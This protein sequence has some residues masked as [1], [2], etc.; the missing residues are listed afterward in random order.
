ML[1][2][3]NP[4]RPCTTAMIALGTL[5]TYATVE[6]SVFSEKIRVP[7]N[8]TGEFHVKLHIIPMTHGSYDIELSN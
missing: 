4:P 8:D 5:F 3:V 2:S 6:L 7:T 1:D